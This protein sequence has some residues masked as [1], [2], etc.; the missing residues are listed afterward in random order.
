VAG[1]AVVETVGVAVAVVAGAVVGSTGVAV[2]PGVRA[3]GVAVAAR[4]MA[5]AVGSGG[6]PWHAASE[7]SNPNAMKKTT[8]RRIKSPPPISNLYS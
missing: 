6:P 7:S 2:G 3:T 8:S 4:G 1:A 5:V